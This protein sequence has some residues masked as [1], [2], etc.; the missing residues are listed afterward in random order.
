M[1]TLWVRAPRLPRDGI[2][3][4]IDR[5]VNQLPQLRGMEDRRQR[6]RRHLGHMTLQ[7]RGQ[8]VIRPHVQVAGDEIRPSPVATVEEEPQVDDA[9][10]GGRLTAISHMDRELLDRTTAKPTV[11][12]LREEALA[13]LQGSPVGEHERARRKRQPQAGPLDV[14]VGLQERPGQG[15]VHPERLAQMRL[16]VDEHP[17]TGR[18]GHRVLRGPL[19]RRALHHLATRMRGQVRHDLRVGRELGLGDRTALPAVHIPRLLRP[20]VHEFLKPRQEGVEQHVGGRARSRVPVDL[21]SLLFRRLAKDGTPRDVL[22]R[23][24]IERGEQV[25]V[26]LLH[27]SASDDG[28]GIR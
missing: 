20:F 27:R 4:R 7:D 28:V 17:D 16:E 3:D 10:S 26:L 15:L 1:A 13:Q 24:T 8:V 9:P 18:D 25:G 14:E 21:P 11:V 6:R 2:E 12:L 5:E 22:G 19:R 23:R